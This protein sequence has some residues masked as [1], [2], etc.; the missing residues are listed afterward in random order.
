MAALI[1]FRNAARTP[2]CSSSRI[3]RVVVPPGDVTASRSST[4]CIRSSRSSFAV[5][6]IVWTTSSV[7]ISRERPS[8]I[9]ASIIASA[10]S[11][12]YA[13]PDPETAVTASMYGS[14]TSTTRPTARSTSAARARCSRPACA[15]AQMPAIPSCTVDGAFGIARTT[16]TP[17]ATSRSMTPVGIAAAIDSTVCRGERTWPTSASSA[18]M[19]CGLTAITTT[20]AS[21]TASAFA[22]VASMPYRSRSSATRSSRRPV[23]TTSVQPELRSPARSDSPI[24]PA[25]RIAMRIR[26]GYDA[27]MM[28]C[29]EVHAR[30]PGPLAVRLEQ[31]VRLLGLHPPSSQRRQQL[32]E[33]E[34]ACEPALEP[35]EALEADE[36]DGP[37]PEPALAPE[38]PRDDVRR[39]RLQRLEVER[40]A[41]ADEGGAAAGAE[42]EVAELGGREAPEVTRSR[43]RVQTV[44]RRRRRA[45]DAPL[46]L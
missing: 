12:K 37:R 6:N 23:T 16:G 35:A 31:L 42:P 43:R 2:A 32:H 1:A 20:S 39:Q 7:E 45:D 24:L 46:V 34:V 14:A 38:P 26:Q 11:A 15:P 17:S 8:R 19:S 40:A 18:S 25:P 44:A 21:R 36:P 13:G 3:A 41:Q 4:G 22:V 9:P 27:C 10:S 30:Q 5:P 28:T 33:A 29:Q